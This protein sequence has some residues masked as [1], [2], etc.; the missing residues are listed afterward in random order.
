MKV[1]LTCLGSTAKL[2]SDE[3]LRKYDPNCVVPTVKQGSEYAKCRDCLSSSDVVNLVFL[4]RSMKGEIYRYILQ[5]KLVE[6]VK[7]LNLN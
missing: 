3:R 6:S 2:W 7:N 1:D 5:K 4:G